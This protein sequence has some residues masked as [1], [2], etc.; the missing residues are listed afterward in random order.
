MEY[1]KI[2]IPEIPD[3]SKLAVI[4]TPNDYIIQDEEL[5]DKNCGVKLA[6]LQA[7]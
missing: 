6:F 3:S 2:I 1:K 5:K 4:D 7:A